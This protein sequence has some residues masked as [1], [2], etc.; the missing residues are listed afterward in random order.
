MIIM[1]IKYK[2]SIITWTNWES[3]NNDASVEI[4]WE[5]KSALSSL[6]IWYFSTA[7]LFNHNKNII[8]RI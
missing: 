6:S 7:S 4:R 1:K 2:S 8:I 3:W 5:T